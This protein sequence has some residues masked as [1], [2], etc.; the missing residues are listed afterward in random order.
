VSKPRVYVETEMGISLGVS[1][2]PGIVYIWGSVATTAFREVARLL[3]VPATPFLR[4]RVRGIEIG[5]N[6]KIG[7]GIGWTA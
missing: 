7:G 3:D 6:A 4:A 1:V 2:E 5:F